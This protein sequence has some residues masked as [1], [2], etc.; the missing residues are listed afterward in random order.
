MYK[1]KYR[2][3]KQKYNKLKNLRNVQISETLDVSDDTHEANIDWYIFFDLLQVSKDIVNL[4]HETDIIILIGDT[5]SYLTPFLELKRRVYNLA[6]S[7]KPFG[8]FFPPYADPAYQFS[9]EGTVYVPF[10]TNLNAYFEYLNSKTFLTKAFVKENWHRI[11][12]VDS[13]SGSSIHGV[14]IF[15]NR[16]VENILRDENIIECVNIKNSKPLK[17][18]QLSSGYYVALN[19]TP[20]KA[21][22]ILPNKDFRQ[23]KYRPVN[24][25]PDLII[26]LGMSVFLYREAFMI[27]D[28]YPRIVP[29][30]SVNIWDVDPN[31]IG[32]TE[33]GLENIKKLGD[34]LK[35]YVQI[36]Q[37][38]SPVSKDILKELDMIEPKISKDYDLIEFLDD[39]NLEVLFEKYKHYFDV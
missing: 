20:T 6:F 38:D 34:L 16:Y 14:S 4:T 1:Q 23:V 15:F 37:N 5:P 26:H 8:C 27:Y 18:I 2:K 21:E 11:V 19:L 25:R 30:Y 35:I 13:S 22:T 36:K 31:T 24:Y 17:F 12:L 29:F 39:I 3:Y 10:R 32:N 33:K 9:K 28:A 7:N